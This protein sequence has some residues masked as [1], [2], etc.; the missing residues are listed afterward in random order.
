MAAT[1]AIPPPG[2]SRRPLAVLNLLARLLSAHAL[3][4]DPIACASLASRGSPSL[5]ARMPSPQLLSSPL[6]L[7]ERTLKAAVGWVIDRM[8]NTKSALQDVEDDA[9]RA[10]RER[11]LG[12]DDSETPA[13]LSDEVCLV[14]GRPV[15]RVEVA[16]GNARRIFTGI[17]IVS[18]EPDVLE[19]VWSTLTDYANLAAVVPNLVSNEVL[20]TTPE[21]GARLQQ[22]GGAKLAPGVVFKATTT[23]DVAV[24]PG[25]LPSTMEA[26][27]DPEIAAAR[28]EGQFIVDSKAV[29]EFGSSLP[30]TKDLFPRAYC[31]S[32]LPHRDITMQGV[33]GLG[34]FR[35][36]Q[37]VWRMQHLPGCAPEGSSA[38]RLTYSVEL[39]PTLWVPVRLLEGRIAAA[40]GENLE[41]IRDYVVAT[42]AQRTTA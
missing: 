16:P 2:S 31:I 8:E 34:D 7:R 10:A 25:G 38:M 29:R 39:S 6:N 24:Y 21:G 18:E 11:A 1:P 14:P 20:S 37:G 19:A 4:V 36:Y 40:L 15:V 12:D 26:P 41:A 35:F 32:S 23:L 17:D 13:V 3:C 9:S 5:P 28:K 27:E 33:A 30:L 42:S 22:V